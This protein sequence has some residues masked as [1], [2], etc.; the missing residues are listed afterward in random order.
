[1]YSGKDYY[2][3][4]FKYKPI[5]GNF[6]EIVLKNHVLSLLKKVSENRNKNKTSSRIF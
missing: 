6:L 1:M 2:F 5:N 3:K 4:G